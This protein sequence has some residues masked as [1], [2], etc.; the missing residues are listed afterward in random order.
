L[1]RREIGH[2]SLPRKLSSLVGLSEEIQAQR[3]SQEHGERQLGGSSSYRKT[4]IG[5]LVC[6]EDT[7]TMQLGRALQIP[8]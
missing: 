5:Q 4:T 1:L 2:K 3:H 8:E 7:G 6:R